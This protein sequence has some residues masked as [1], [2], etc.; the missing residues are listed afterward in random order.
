MHQTNAQWTQ[1]GAEGLTSSASCKVRVSSVENVSGEVTY[2][3]SR[4]KERCVFELALKL[5]LEMELAEGGELKTI[6]T[7]QLNIPEVLISPHIS[8]RTSP[9]PSSHCS[10]HCFRLLSRLPSPQLVILRA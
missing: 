4:G 8:P 1:A 7:G 3:L 6:L 2:V 5:K 9:Q 10:T